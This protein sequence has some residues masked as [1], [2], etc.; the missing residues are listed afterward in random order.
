VKYTGLR[1]LDQDGT[2]TITTRDTEMLV[3]PLAGTCTVEVENEKFDL[4]GRTGVFAGVTDSPTCQGMRRRQSPARAASRCR[5]PGP[6]AGCPPVTARPGKVPVE[7]RGARNCSRQ[8]HN[9][10]RKAYENYS[11][12]KRNQTHYL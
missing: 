11:A 5:R 1:V 8:V 3:L 12:S 9:S 6:S 2:E 7:L 10:T 4:T